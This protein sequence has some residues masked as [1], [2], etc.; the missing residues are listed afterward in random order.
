MACGFCVGEWLLGL[1]MYRACEL[2]D[3]A[4]Q[5]S[6]LRAGQQRCKWLEGRRNVCW[7]G[8]MSTC[9][10]AGSMVLHA[11]ARGQ[12]NWH[13][14]SRVQLPGCNCPGTAASLVTVIYP[15]PN[16]VTFATDDRRAG[17]CICDHVSK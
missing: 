12:Q 8:C 7:L 3:G 14:I 4:V 6:T 15:L 2:G 13:T 5:L 17:H 16:T 1:G 9:S 10:M 11:H